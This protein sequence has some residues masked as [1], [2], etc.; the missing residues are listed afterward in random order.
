MNKD[1]K[2]NLRK[3]WIRVAPKSYVRYAYK[4]H[5]GVYPNLKKPENFNEKILWLIFNWQHP[6]LVQCTDKFNMRN[7]VADCGLEEILPKLYGSW[8]DA[9]LVEWDK[10]PEQ[11]AIKCNHGCEMNIIC[12]NKADIN[13]ALASK[14]LNTWLHTR[15]GADKFYEPHYLH[16]KPIIFAEEYIKTLDGK[17]PI[18]YKIYCFN[19]VPELALACVDRETRVKFEFYDLQWNVLDIGA[20]KNNMKARRPI[21]LDKMVEYSRILSKPF[22]FVRVDFY[23]RDGDPVLGELTFTPFYGMARYYSEEGNL[24]LGNKLE[25][26]K[27]YKR[28]Y[29]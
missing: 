28:N 10:L 14:Q 20:E 29:T 9:Q 27:K 22:P 1:F 23:D 3:L 5:F 26:P 21:S 18:D 4:I 16:I 19:G 15:Y 11:Y 12:T 13:I 24:W 6:L 2:E 17:L 7:Y 8:T 25:L